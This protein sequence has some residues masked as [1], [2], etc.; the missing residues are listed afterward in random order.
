MGQ[1][2]NNRMSLEIDSVIIKYDIY[3]NNFDDITNLLL[4]H[5][6]L[7]NDK[8]DDWHIKVKPSDLYQ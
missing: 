3:N 4:E 5:L 8:S 1:L 2:I 7:T 6:Y